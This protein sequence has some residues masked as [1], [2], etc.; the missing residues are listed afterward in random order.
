MM[1]QE[2]WCKLPQDFSKLT[3]WQIVNIYYKPALERQKAFRNQ[4]GH[5]SYEP[6]LRHGSLPR[7]ELPHPDIESPLFKDWFIRTTC[8]YW[9]MDR[10][11]QEFDL[12]MKEYREAPPDVWWRVKK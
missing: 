3:D 9:G 1:A 12:Q 4:S 11:K 10:A 6:T 8:T 5:G 2:P 7:E